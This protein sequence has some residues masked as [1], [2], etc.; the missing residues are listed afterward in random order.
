MAPDTKLVEQLVEII[1]RE[2]LLAMVE[3]EEQ[4]KLPD[5]SYCRLKLPRE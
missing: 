3:Q 1:T 2:V 4:E 5:G